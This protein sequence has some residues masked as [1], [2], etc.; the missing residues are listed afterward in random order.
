MKSTSTWLFCFGTVML[1]GG[2]ESLA[3]NVPSPL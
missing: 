1:I 2:V 3:A